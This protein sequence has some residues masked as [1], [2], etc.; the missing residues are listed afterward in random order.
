MQTSSAQLTPTPQLSS[1]LRDLREANLQR[2]TSEAT[3]LGLDPTLHP[4]A[5]AVTSVTDLAPVSPARPTAPALHVAS[6]AST[7]VPSAR[8][9][10][11][12]GVAVAARA[13][14]RLYAVSVLTKEEGITTTIDKDAL[15]E[16]KLRIRGGVAIF[17]RVHGDVVVDDEAPP[18]RCTVLIDRDA[19][20]EGSVV[21]H[22]IVINGRV[23]GHV[24][25]KAFLVLAE[26]SVVE[27]DVR[28]HRMTM[29]DTAT[30][31]GKFSKLK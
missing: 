25:A 26:S 7:G 18:N 10:G 28:Y 12:A 24:T 27:G 6:S 20:V 8:D 30:I 16:G 15:F 17:G 14:E 29:A 2:R 3:A 5:P 22:K 1:A 23:T 31:E 9:N 13:S 21:G 4:G 19:V 11:P